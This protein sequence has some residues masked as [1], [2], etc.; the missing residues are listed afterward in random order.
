[1]LSKHSGWDCIRP[2]R[3]RE[4]IGEGSGSFLEVLM[5]SVKRLRVERSEGLENNNRVNS[6]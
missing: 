5:E 1:M 2:G 4:E 6:R 3:E